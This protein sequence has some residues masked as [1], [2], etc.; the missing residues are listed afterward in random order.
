MS[1]VSGVTLQVGGDEDAKIVDTVVMAWLDAHAFNPMA[2]LD[3]AYGGTKSP[4]VYVWGAGYNY[5]EAEAFSELI[6]AQSWAFPENVVLLIN[7]EDEA[8]MVIRP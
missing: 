7:A 6:R 5:F 3:G 1:L 8:T 2:R 4:Q